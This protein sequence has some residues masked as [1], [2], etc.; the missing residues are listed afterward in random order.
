M[1]AEGREETWNQ[2]SV[3]RQL[4]RRTSFSCWFSPIIRSPAM[5]VVYEIEMRLNYV[6]SI[7]LCMCLYHLRPVE[8]LNVKTMR[9]YGNMRKYKFTSLSPLSLIYFF[10][11]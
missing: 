10:K 8:L 5:K 1:W 4:W 9:K 2:T 6:Y 3:G 7:F 11:E